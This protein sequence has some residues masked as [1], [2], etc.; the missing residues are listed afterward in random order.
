MWTGNDRVSRSEK[1]EDA[2][3]VEKDKEDIEDAEDRE[4][5]ATASG[6][7]AYTHKQIFGD[8]G[9]TQMKVL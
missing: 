8:S 4:D 3:Q 6:A 1:N 9:E 2:A 7:P 5:G